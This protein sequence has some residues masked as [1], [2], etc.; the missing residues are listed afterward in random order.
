MPL[1]TAFYELGLRLAIGLL[2]IVVFAVMLGVTTLPLFYAVLFGANFGVNLAQATGIRI[3]NYFGLMFRNITRNLLRT[4]LT[5]VAI[6]VLVFVISGIWTMLNFIDSITEEKQNDLKAIITEKYQIPSQMPR[7]FEDDIKR[8]ASGLPEGMKPKNGDDDIMTW[9]FVGGSTDPVNKTL[10]NTVFFFAMEPRKLLTMM[11]GLNEL[12]STELSLL[13]AGVA[14][15]ERNPQA[16]IIGEE[17]LELM[18]KRVG[19]R[20]KIDSFNYPGITFEYEIIGSFPKDSRYAQSAVM[21]RDY[22][23]KAIDEHERKTGK[24]EFSDKCL[25]LIWVR[26]PSTEAFE[27]MA[28]RVHGEAYTDEATRGERRERFSPGIKMETASTAFGAFLDPYR[29]IFWGMRWIFSPMIIVIITLIIAIAV[30]I[31]VRERRT[32]MAVLKVLGFKPWQVLAL[33]LIEALLVGIISGAISSMLVYALVNWGG[34]LPIKVAFFPKFA[35]TTSVLTWGPII[36]AFA[37]FVG[38]IVPAWNTHKIK[39]AEVFA[40]VA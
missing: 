19:D 10:K 8:I 24:T 29:D 31:G 12:S 40:R 26:L 17:K 33:V 21:T 36:G 18:E 4:S 7:K 34:G 32:E 37:S 35:L 2:L 25:N 38:S 20:F 6:F 30:S 1:E 9:A 39:A 23:Y 5:Y 13:K 22:F 27:V 15:M 3:F 14:E 16:C 11:D 28:A